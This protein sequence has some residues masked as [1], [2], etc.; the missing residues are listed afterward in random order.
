MLQRTVVI[1][2]GLSIEI[3]NDEHGKH[4]YWVDENARVA[5]YPGE[6]KYMLIALAAIHRE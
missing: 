4:F 5:F 3:V 2:T 1:D 6:V